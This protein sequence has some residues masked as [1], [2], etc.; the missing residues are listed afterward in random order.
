MRSKWRCP[1]NIFEGPDA[2]ANGDTEG[3]RRDFSQAYEVKV[4]PATIRWEMLP[5]AL[6]I[7]VI[8]RRGGPE[9]Q[10]MWTT[11]EQVLAR[12]QEESRIQVARFRSLATDSTVFG[13]AGDHGLVRT[14]SALRLYYSSVCTVCSLQLWL[15]VVFGWLVFWSLGGHWYREGLLWM[16]VM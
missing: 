10:S 4:D 5:D 3:G 9:V 2:L 16:S 14:Y 1:H 15:G 12:A 7:G 13:K 11:S 8:G 6:A